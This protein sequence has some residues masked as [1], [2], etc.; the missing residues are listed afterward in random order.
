MNLI[1]FLRKNFL[2]TILLL[3]S[4]FNNVIY[5]QEIQP[6]AILKN[7]RIGMLS[8]NYGDSIALRWG[9]ASSEVWN[10]GNKYGY[11]VE[12]KT[13]IR[14]KEILYDN[15]E[16]IKLTSVPLK[17]ALLPEMEIMA[18]ADDR[19]A[20][21]AQAIYGSTFEVSGSASP[22]SPISIINKARELDNRFSFALFAADQSIIAAK[23]HGLFFID[24]NI[25][26]DEQYLYR[27]YIAFPD[28]QIKADTALAFINPA[29][30]EILPKPIGLEAEF[31][32]RQAIL[33]WDKVLLERFYASYSVERSNDGGKTFL[34]VNNLPFINPVKENEAFP[35]KYIFIDSLPVNGYLFKYRVKGKS[36]FGETGPPSDTVDGAG[37]AE[38]KDFGPEITNYR[39]LNNNMVIFEWRVPQEFINDISGF[40]ILRS[41]RIDGTYKTIN[42]EVLKPDAKTFVDTIAMTVNYYQVVAIDMQGRKH[43]S[44]SLMVQLE[45]SIPPMVPIGLKGI[46]DSTGLVSISWERNSE[47]D[48]S[49][50]NVFRANNPEAEFI[51]INSAG[52]FSNSY[53]D[54]ISLQSLSPKVYYKVSAIDKHYNQSLLSNA[55][56]VRRPDIIAPASPSLESLESNDSCILIKWNR[57]PSIDVSHYI[58]IRTEAQ[59]SL[60]TKSTIIKAE[61][62]FFI[63]NDL[64]AGT[65][66][67]YQLVAVDSSRNI[68]KPLVF[69]GR[70]ANVLRYADEEVKNISFSKDIENGILTLKWEHPGKNVRKYIIYR[71]VGDGEILRYR[72]VEG[73]KLQ[74][75]DNNVKRGST[76]SYRMQVQYENGR[77]LRLSEALKIE[78]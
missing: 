70:A 37:F 49:G 47:P 59:D 15:T 12:R 72:A 18:N 27:V 53:T 61:N 16:I 45:D 1:E 6:K 10:Y 71:S 54:T 41:R 8:C 75:N 21:V 42:K 9:P 64:V 5:A 23:A 25:K 63:D 38:I 65:E 74:F 50:Y 3:I 46:A 55:L 20:I 78:F 56:S 22:A 36:F 58:L 51:K 40:E 57:S 14:G 77:L 2:N 19:V 52:V 68:S 44:L 7:T 62:T 34:P 76:Y 32:N 17:P 69:T 60:K 26:K 73:S 4:I 28:S 30:K 33:T 24:R 43:S 29:E 39:I 13:I 67:N 48:L 35:H 66:Y 31:G 11:I